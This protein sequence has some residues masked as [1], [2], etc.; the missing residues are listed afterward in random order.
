MMESRKPKA[1]SKIVTLTFSINPTWE[2]QLSVVKREMAKLS[3]I[4]AYIL[5]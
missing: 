4:E 2:K 1:K 5:K 3:K